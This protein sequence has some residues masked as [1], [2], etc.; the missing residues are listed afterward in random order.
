[1]IVILL[2]T[3]AVATTAVFMFSPAAAGMAALGYV[4]MAVFFLISTHARYRHLARLSAYLKRVNSGDYALELPDNDEGELSILKS[5]IYKVTT[6]LRQQNESLRKEK[7]T[8]A[9]SLSDISHQ[10]KTPLTSMF[11]MIDILS[12]E[13]LPE[14]KRT[15]FTD[16]IRQQLERLQWLVESLLKISKLDAE[17]VTFRIRPV[18][19]GELIEKARVLLNIPME[20]KNQTLSVEEGNGLS[21]DC[22]LN[23]T[24]EALI[25]ILKNCVEYTPS[26]GNIR[27]AFSTNLLY[28]QIRV[29]DSGPG[30]DKEDLPLIFNRFYKGKH[31]GNDS[32]G[33]GLAMAKSIVEAQGGSLTA[34]NEPGGAM[35]TLR[36]PKHDVV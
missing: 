8:L 24:A 3:A 4:F 36:F 31:S 17:A 33:I 30:I 11:M 25:N 6:T 35:F 27:I 20:L 21:M 19:P 12:G 32:V 10:L 28:T 26:G 5:E 23:W 9:A 15:E 29:S 2:L 13:N 14:E 16:C 7:A 18:S 1:M 34:E 22:D